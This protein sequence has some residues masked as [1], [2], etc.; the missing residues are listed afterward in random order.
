M[1]IKSGD[2]KIRKHSP[3]FL[4]GKQQRMEEAEA[5][6]NAKRETGVQRDVQ[7]A[8]DRILADVEKQAAAEEAAEAKRQRAEKAAAANEKAAEA[9]R[10]RDVQRAVDRIL[11][12]VEKQ[13]AAE[14]AAE[15]K[16]QRAE[17]AADAKRQR[18]KRQR[19]KLTPITNGQRYSPDEDPEVQAALRRCRQHWAEKDA[20]DLDASGVLDDATVLDRAA[21]VALLAECGIFEWD[22]EEDCNGESQYEC[23]VRETMTGA[24]NCGCGRGY[25]GGW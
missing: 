21:A 11:A 25:G 6:L 17:E 23:H 20:L 5:R 2:P 7:R 19:P 14:E 1:V 15:A 3:E 12:G 4:M 18:A 22:C 24:C 13:A 9:K 10:Q 16:R 8:L